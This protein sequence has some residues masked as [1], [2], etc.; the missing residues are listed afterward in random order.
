MGYPLFMKPFDG[1]GWRGVSR[2]KDET[3][4]HAAYDE[5]GEMLMH[6]QKSVEPLRRVRPLADHR[7]GDDGHALPARPADARPLRGR[8]RLPDPGRGQ[9]AITIAQTVNAF[10]RW[11]FN[12]CE[13]LVQGDTVL[14][15]DYANACPDVALT[16]LHYYFPW[17]MRALVTWTV[18][19]AVT[20]RPA[21]L[22]VDPT[23]WFDVADD[24]D[25][26][27]G[28]KLGRY[29]DGRRV[30][31][32]R[33][34]PRVLRD[35]AARIDEIVLDWVA[36]PDFDPLLVETVRRPTRR[37]SRSGSSAHFRGLIG[38]WVTDERGRRG[39]RR[40]DPAA[41]TRPGSGAEQVGLPRDGR[42]GRRR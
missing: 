39:R 42:R 31:R 13:M 16:S 2:I 24:P 35:G 19:C 32:D 29:R 26:N 3:A 21:R 15:I 8:A 40:L 37:T 12:S 27:Y 38:L 34:L 30:L 6:L 23:P 11:E 20:G 18:F 28:D 14:P 7:S 9:E 10:F 4:L 5:S 33:A 22:D 41:G 1:G 25:L 36:S 17:A